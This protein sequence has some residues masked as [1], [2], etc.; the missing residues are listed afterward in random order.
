MREC[1]TVQVGQCGNQIGACFWDL[2]VKEHASIAKDGLF[3]ASMST[4]FRNVDTRYEN[5]I[6]IPFGNGKE[7]IK[8]LK[9]RAVLVDTEEGN[10]VKQSLC[11]YCI[12]QIDIA[13]SSFV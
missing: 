1:I 4:F 12:S 10:G 13:V 6:D 5:P 9:A 11:I 2:V 3:D 7:Q 8:F